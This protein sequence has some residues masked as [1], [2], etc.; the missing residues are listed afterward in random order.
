[1]GI[2]KDMESLEDGIR[3]IGSVLRQNYHV[4]QHN[5]GSKLNSSTIQEAQAASG[6]E[7]RYRKS[8]FVSQ[9]KCDQYKI[10]KDSFV[11]YLQY[12]KTGEIY[13]KQ[14]Q[15]A[16]A[17][18]P[19]TNPAQNQRQT[20]AYKPKIS[21]V[22]NNT[23]G[24]I[25]GGAPKQP[26]SQIRRT[27]TSNPAREI[28]ASLKDSRVNSYYVIAYYKNEDAKKDEEISVETFNQEKE[29]ELIEFCK[30]M[31]INGNGKGGY[32]FQKAETGNLESVIVNY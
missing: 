2:Q 24:N 4:Y 12:V 30:K 23:G 14:V 16:A 6:K 27:Y 10:L 32:V 7:E 26:E 17:T 20:I 3:H 8:I 9:K 13:G 5:V 19:T 29:K 22:S 25:S 21:L 18:V 15:Q 11:A 28:I 31:G 1:M